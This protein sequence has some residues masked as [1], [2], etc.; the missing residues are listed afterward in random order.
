MTFHERKGEDLILAFPTPVLAQVVH[1]VEGFNRELR[2]I[3]EERARAD[4]GSGGS[5]VGGWHSEPDFFTWPHPHAQ[6]LLSWV[7]DAIARI[8]RYTGGGDAGEIQLQAAAWANVLGPGGY[9]TPHTHPACMW[10]GVYYVETGTRPEGATSSGL[11]EFQ[12]P[13]NA[14]EMIGVPGAPFAGKLTFD[15]EPGLMLVFPS[16][17]S[18]YVHPYRGEGLRV[19]IAFNVQLVRERGDAPQDRNPSVQRA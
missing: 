13:R 11:I 4:A 7:R 8:T 19:S 15:P 3:V 18:H 14:V 2:E 5:N 9:N 1:G 17:L 16:W 6:Q 10:S 12:D